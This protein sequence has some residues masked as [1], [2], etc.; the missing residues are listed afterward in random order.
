MEIVNVRT[1]GLDKR[2]LDPCRAEIRDPNDPR[3]TELEEFGDMMKNMG[4]K[5]GKRKKQLSRDTSKAG[6]H[7]F[8]GLAELIRY[9]NK[10]Y[11]SVCPLVYKK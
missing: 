4:A 1:A 8:H 7:T 6:Y 11:D 9:A 10:S 2:L 3:L 5:Q